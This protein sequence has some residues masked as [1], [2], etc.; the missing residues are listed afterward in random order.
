MRILKNTK[1]HPTADWVYQ[2]ARKE[3]PNISLGTVY[4]NLRKLSEEGMIQ[5]LAFGSSFDRYDADTSFHYH[6]TCRKCGKVY[7]IA[8]NGQQKLLREVQKKRG[9]QVE[10]VRMEFYGICTACKK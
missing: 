10:G 4:R 6:F 1:S 7:D 5:K 9:F 3:I 2:K 8:P